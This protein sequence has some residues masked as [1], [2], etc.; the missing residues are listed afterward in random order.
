MAE[1]TYEVKVR[2]PKAMPQWVKV[3]ANSI[4]N[5]QAMVEAQYGKG[6]ILGG[7]REVIK[8]YAKSQ[9]SAKKQSAKGGGGAKMP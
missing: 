4:R 6:C 3:Q 9:S 8:K 7:P 2:L 5:A 1:K